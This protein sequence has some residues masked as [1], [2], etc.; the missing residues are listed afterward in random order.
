MSVIFKVDNHTYESLDPNDGIKWMSTTRFIEMFKHKFDPIETSIKCAKNKKSKWY[1]IPPTEIQRIWKAETDRAIN[2]GDFYHSQREHD[3]SDLDSIERCGRPIPVIRPIYD[4]KT[5]MAPDQQLCEGIYPE[6]FMYLKS[7]GICGQSDRVEIIKDSVDVFDYKGLALDTPIATKESWKLMSEIQVGDSIFDKYGDIT[8]VT[9]VSEIHYNPCYK[10]TFDTNDSIVCDHEHLWEVSFWRDKTTTVQKEMTTDKMFEYI[11]SVKRTSKTIMKIKCVTS[12]LMSDKIL[13]IDPYI[14]GAWLG[15]GS[16]SCGIITNINPIF[17]TH[18]QARGYSIGPDLSDD[19]H[20]ETRTI[21]NIRG[22]LNKLG[23]LNNKHIPDIYLR[24]SHSQRLDLLRGLMDTDGYFNK[25]R[26]RFVMATTQLW[27]AEDIS[28]LISSLGWKPTIIKATKYCNNKQFQGYDVC[29]KAF[30]NPF[31]IRNTECLNKLG[32]IDHTAKY[33]LIN[34]IEK[35]NTVPTRCLAVDSPTHTYL[36][37][38]NLITTHNTNK[39]I[40]KESFKNWEGLSKRMLDPIAHLDDCN[41]MH[42]SLQLS[43]Y[44][45]MIL[46]HNPTLKPGKLIIQHII[47][48]KEGDDQYGYPILKK[49]PQGNYIVKTVIPYECPFLRNEVRSMINWY[50]EKNK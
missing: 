8:K 38:Y 9:H 36:A 19:N 14:L 22:E 45:H 50:M 47:F 23:L 15:D 24:A 35:V 10:I 48:E 25:T 13:P 46:K 18:I 4:G 37:G 5:K 17:W 41:F 34:N 26:K 20:A 32:P 30:E 12:L 27:Q 1:G 43:M 16:K 49:D 39:K 29:F 33:R 28:K 11:N 44:M 21:L 3:V 6:H 7:A 42:Y 31:L 40:D 2:T